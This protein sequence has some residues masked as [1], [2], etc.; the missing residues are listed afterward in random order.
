MSGTFEHVGG[1]WEG[2]YL[3][4]SPEFVHDYFLSQC[5]TAAPWGLSDARSHFVASDP[6]TPLSAAASE[7]VCVP[8]SIT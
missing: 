7:C 4:D 5:E 3:H 1:C 8:R 6:V 2:Q